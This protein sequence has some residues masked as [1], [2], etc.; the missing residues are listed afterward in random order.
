MG[1]HSAP[2]SSVNTKAVAAILTTFIGGGAA[3][4]AELVHLI[5]SVKARAAHVEEQFRTS[6]PDTQRRLDRLQGNLRDLR[7]EVTDLPTPRAI[8]GP[9]GP[10]GPAVVVTAAPQPVTTAATPTPTPTCR[11]PVAGICLDPKARTP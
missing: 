11:T 10:P 1:R 3:G 5:E 4:A 8:P 2:G 7:T 6:V 9:P